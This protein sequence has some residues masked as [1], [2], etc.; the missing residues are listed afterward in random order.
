MPGK[1]KNIWFRAIFVLIGIFVQNQ[2]VAMNPNGGTGS[3]R[4]WQEQWTSDFKEC[5]KSLGTHINQEVPPDA[6]EYCSSDDPE[7][8]YLSVFV[9]LAGKESNYNDQAKGQNGGRVP[10]GLFQ[11]DS[12]D[13]QSHKCEGTNPLDAKENICCAVKIADDSSLGGREVEGSHKLCDSNHGIM[14]AF[15]QPMR[16]GV[17]GNGRGGTMDNTSVHKDLKRVAQ[18]VCEA[19][20][21]AATDSYSPNHYNS[22]RFRRGAPGKRVR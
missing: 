8:V 7:K 18:Q 17:G 22:G 5:F 19:G 12:Q 14:D 15:W 1:F 3:A 9:A 6:G 16:D 10:Q 2:A 20:T 4:G 21:D 11:M 13:M